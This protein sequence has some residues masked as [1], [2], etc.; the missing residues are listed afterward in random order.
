MATH[1]CE[2]SE[3]KK[4]NYPGYGISSACYSPGYIYDTND[5]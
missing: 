5:Q 4:D 1:V 3:G 2:F